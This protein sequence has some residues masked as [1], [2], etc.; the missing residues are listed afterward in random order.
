MAKPKIFITVASRL[1]T[2]DLSG[3]AL[4]EDGVL[5]ASYV[6]SNETWLQHDMGITSTKQHSKYAAHYPDG[7]ELVWV[8]TM[9]L[10]S[11]SN[12]GFEAAY[13]R[14]MQMMKEASDD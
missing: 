13:Q 11:R 7:Y 5:L 2:G 8:S 6:S 12:R 14:R 9:E 10:G 3:V 1:Q 4:A